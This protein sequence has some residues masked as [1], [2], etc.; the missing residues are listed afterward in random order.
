MTRRLWLV[1]VVLAG[2][3][4][5]QHSD[6]REVTG[7]VTYKGQPVPYGRVSFVSAADPLVQDSC[8]IRP[9]GTYTL[10]NAPVGK[11][12]VVLAINGG[13]DLQALQA[14]GEKAPPPF[15]P[16]ELNAKYMS[17]ET[18]PLEGTVGAGDEKIDLAIK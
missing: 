2:C 10:T 8:L 9:D 3:A 15:L 18:T 5:P 6:R 14:R 4:Q 11:V 16:H 13:V 12:K 1:V 7:V 17:A